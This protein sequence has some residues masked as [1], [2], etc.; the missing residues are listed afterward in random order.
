M[1]NSVYL[2]SVNKCESYENN[3]VRDSL[4]KCLKDID[5]K[6]KKNQTIL[7]KPNILSANSPEK[8]V[9]THPSIIEELCKILK[10]YDSEIY[11]GDSSAINTDK[12]LDESGMK[13]LSKY[14]KVVNLEDYD[15]IY[16]TTSAKN[17]K[18]P[19]SKLVFDVD[20]VINV[21]K[22]KT[23]SLTKV[24]LAVKNLYGCIPG[25]TKAYL[26][27]K[28]AKINDF[29]EFLLE[30]EKFISPQLNII[31]GVYGLEGEGP[32][33][34]GDKIFAGIILASTS[35]RAID[36]VASEKVGF[37][38]SEILTNNLSKIN[39]NDIK[40][41]GDAKDINLK[42]KKPKSTKLTFSPLIK[43]LFPD[44]KIGFN[45]EVCKKCNICKNQCP[46]SAIKLSPY[47]IVDH[48]KCIRCFCCL[49]VC[50][51]KAVIVKESKLKQNLKSVKKFTYKILKKQK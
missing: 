38:A 42:F 46:V 5:F 48:N 23:H 47:P 51:H 18:Y 13:N 2:V 39:T 31:D 50:P 15:K 7:I 11:I 35:A 27:N 43:M 40:I 34:A 44:L 19:L 21:A 12:A 24:T 30:N 14:A 26:H 20:L 16:F 25:R 6:F 29:S 9:T 36:I 3:L 4:L 49:E 1:K 10:K 41:I 37:K 22:L 8:A 32:G 17:I 28:L 45:N 33:T